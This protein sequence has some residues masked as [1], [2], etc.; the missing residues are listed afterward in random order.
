MSPTYA[1]PEVRRWPDEGVDAVEVGPN[2]ARLNGA[3]YSDKTNNEDRSQQDTTENKP[4]PRESVKPIVEIGYENG[5][6][7]HDSRELENVNVVTIFAGG[8]RVICV[9]KDKETDNGLEIVGFS[10]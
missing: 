8:C 7:G 9:E 5:C 2:P 10:I 1:Q 4:I 3:I 6:N